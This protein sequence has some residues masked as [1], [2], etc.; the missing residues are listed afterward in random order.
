V[1]CILLE[2][3]SQRCAEAVGEL[4]SRGFK[5]PIQ[6]I[7]FGLNGSFIFGNFDGEDPELEWEM[8]GHGLEPGEFQFP[9]NMFFVDLRGIGARV[10]LESSDQD[11]DVEILDDIEEETEPPQRVQ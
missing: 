11:I 5:G 6:T 4:L 1:E 9:I 7:V 3:V 2:L 8:K 10:R